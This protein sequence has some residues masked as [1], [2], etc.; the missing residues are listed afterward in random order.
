MPPGNFFSGVQNGSSQGVLFSRQSPARIGD[1]PV[2]SS[3]FPEREEIH[4][5]TVLLQQY[6]ETVNVAGITLWPCAGS[7]GSF[8]LGL[9]LQFWP[10]HRGMFVLRPSRESNSCLVTSEL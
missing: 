6:L 9:I 1:G 2:F 4:Q 7:L 3:L 8:L 5:Q 10:V